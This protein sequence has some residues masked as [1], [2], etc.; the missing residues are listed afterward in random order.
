MPNK[1]QAFT[2]LTLPELP[3]VPEEF[4]SHAV[5]TV[6]ESLHIKDDVLVKLSIS[7]DEY[8]NRTLIKDNKQIP[9]LHQRAYP[10]GDKWETWVKE[11]ITRNFYETSVRVSY[12][13]IDATELGPHCDG[14]KLRLYYLIERGGE[15]V[16]TNFFL[17]PN[18]P[19]V[20][21]VTD[22][23]ITHCDNLD[24]LQVVDTAKFPMNT[25]IILNSHVL[26][27]VSGAQSGRR[28]NL[29]ITIPSDSITHSIKFK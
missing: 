2:W 20:R 21:D 7:N 8:R 19:L 6:E 12:G 17:E 23:E 18:Y 1:P 22:D 13:D 28:I 16:I 25:W 10:L 27:G 4:L 11:N 5:K 3:K 29:S 9:T 15:D 24:K 14:P 26:H